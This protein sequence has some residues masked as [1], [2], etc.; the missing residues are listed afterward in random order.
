MD[1]AA[2][3]VRNMGGGWVVAM[4]VGC[5]AITCHAEVFSLP[6]EELETFYGGISGITYHEGTGDF[7][8]EFV[9]IN[10]AWLHV[11]GGPSI[12]PADVTVTGYLEDI[13]GPQVWIPVYTGPGFAVDVPLPPPG[14]DFLLDGRGVIGLNIET[15]AVCCDHGTTVTKA[16]L[17]LNAVPDTGVTTVPQLIWGPD[18]RLTYDEVSDSAP[19]MAVH[20]TELHVLWNYSYDGEIRHA[21][22][23]HDVWQSLG[24]VAACPT[25]SGP[26]IASYSEGLYAFY[27]EGSYP[28]YHL[29][30]RNLTDG[31][32]S[33][34]LTNGD[35][36]DKYGA[37]AIVYQGTLYVFWKRWNAGPRYI[38]YKTFNGNAWSDAHTV[39]NDEYGDARPAVAVYDGQLYLFYRG[40]GKYRT[41]NGISWSDENVLTAHTYGNITTAACE[42]CRALY[43]FF[44][45][46]GE[47]RYRRFEG[48]RWGP[49]RRVPASPPD[50]VRDLAVASHNGK[51]HLLWG[52]WYSWSRSELYAKV[53]WLW[54]DYNLD[55]GVG[56][57]D[58]TGFAD[59]LTG[60]DGMLSTGCEVFDSED[61]EDVDL[62]DAAT[63]Q[64]AFTGP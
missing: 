31:S 4:V 9:T 24:T 10:G 53:A 49:L 47:V 8:Q 44:V 58:H 11:E 1:Y 56:L 32:P 36:Y 48:T 61:D 15:Y 34:A 20:D 7:G 33:F 25:G 42:Y 29:F 3:R 59:C 14:F 16:T 41:F 2:G 35:V 18:M 23:D 55:C 46:G 64:R 13:D 30:G 43:V 19:A 26:G 5:S 37:A 39:A 45:S 17:W 27:A 54:G 62:A 6:V 40:G 57:D 28:V 60:P 50:E 22:L 51:L 63:F 12:V 38:L 52:S 21:T